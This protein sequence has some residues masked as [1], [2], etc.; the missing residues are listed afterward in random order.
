M[1]ETLLVLHP[2]SFSDLLARLSQH[3]VNQLQ[4]SGIAQ[5]RHLLPKDR[6]PQLVEVFL[7]FAPAFDRENCNVVR[8]APS[9]RGQ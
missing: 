6:N 9:G 5:S 3:L 1:K 7:D 4:Q 2:S 8:F